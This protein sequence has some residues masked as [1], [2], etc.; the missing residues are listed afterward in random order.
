MWL[1]Q[2][3]EHHDDCTGMSDN[4]KPS[5]GLNSQYCVCY[6]NGDDVDYAESTDGAAARRVQFDYAVP[7]V[8]DEDGG[9]ESADAIDS[10]IV[11]LCT[12]DFAAGTYRITRSGTYVLDCDVEF[13]PNPPE[14]GD[15]SANDPEEYGWFPL[16]EQEE[17]YR[18]GFLD[19]SYVVLWR[20]WLNLKLIV[21]SVLTQIHWRVSVG[22]HRRSHD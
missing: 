4:S 11:H 8:D 13:E 21:I 16:P 17:L 1:Y 15:E 6:R 22:L 20:C 12:A 5:L 18:T 2:V 9:G 3:Y 7:V 10:N 14:N 19:N